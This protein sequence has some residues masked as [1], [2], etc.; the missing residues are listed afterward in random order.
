[1]FTIQYVQPTITIDSMIR[2]H[3]SLELGLL[4]EMLFFVE[5]FEKY[6]SP[7][8]V[9]FEILFRTLPCYSALTATHRLILT[10]LYSSEAKGWTKS[11]DQSSNNS[12]ESDMCSL[13]R[14]LQK[15]HTQPRGHSKQQK[16]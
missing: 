7:L 1:M 10:V 11:W 9:S 5:A 13:A 16:R 6:T 4:R 15:L 3:I 2:F 14:K 12:E 8:Q